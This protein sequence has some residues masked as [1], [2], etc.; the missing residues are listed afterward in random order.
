M[1]SKVLALDVGNV[2]IGVAMADAELRF[3]NPLTTLINDDAIWDTLAALVQENQVEV[4]VVGLPRS[5]QGN[6]TPQTQICRLFAE[7]LPERLQMSQLAIKLQDE[8]ATSVKA[9]EELRA[10][11][12]PYQKADIDALAATYI[13]EDYLNGD[14]Y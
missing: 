3:A 13:L 4:V 11:G 1:A 14:R 7:N 8:A 12:K 6:E 2:R 5:L 9:E 10:R